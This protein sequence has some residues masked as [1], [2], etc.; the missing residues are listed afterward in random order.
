MFDER[1]RFFKP[2]DLSTKPA[3]L[4]RGRAARSDLL[5]DVPEKH[6]SR[7]TVDLPY[8]GQS[9]SAVVALFNPVIICPIVNR[10]NYQQLEA[11]ES[12]VKKRLDLG[13]KA[14]SLDV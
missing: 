8:G 11:L 12:L 13:S 6:D 14:I 5:G 9:W 7:D 4:H 2:P 10:L 1:Q 3:H